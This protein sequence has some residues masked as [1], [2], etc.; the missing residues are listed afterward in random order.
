MVYWSLDYFREYDDAIKEAIFDS[1]EEREHLLKEDEKKSISLLLKELEENDYLEKS[2]NIEYLTDQSIEYFKK[3]ELEIRSNNIKILLEEGKV[4]EAED[5]VLG[6]KKISKITSNWINPLDTKEIQKH[7]DHKAEPLFRFPGVLGDFLGPFESGWL[8][9]ITG[10]YKRGKTFYLQ[11][12]AIIAMLSRIPVVFFSLEMTLDQMKERFYKRLIPSLDNKTGE[13]GYPVFDCAKNQSGGC[14]LPIRANSITLLNS[15]GTK[16]SFSMDMKYKICDKCRLE[17]PNDFEPD[18]WYDTLEVPEYNESTIGNSLE[19]IR[20]F[21]NSFYRM[22][23]YPRF[24]ANLSDLERDLDILEKV[25]GYVPRMIVVDYADILKPEREELVG[26]LKED[27]TWMAL[28]R[29]ASARNALVV[30]GTQATGDALNVAIVTQRHTARWKGKLG[31]ID[32]MLALNQT[33]DE[34][35]FGIMRV[36]VM[37][38]RHKNFIETDTVTVLQQLTIGQAHL[39]STYMQDIGE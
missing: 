8:V 36:S 38:H 39:D 37:A 22:K 6:F 12:F 32:C 30:T 13:I 33:R 9:G 16:P 11:E 35:E 27:E 25:E 31:H 17:S 21:Y 15:D 23:A 24:S 14:Q 5:E 26:V 19:S 2:L 7:F 29:L 4:N 10:P 20:R 18:T 28:A 1:Y 34:K 3:R